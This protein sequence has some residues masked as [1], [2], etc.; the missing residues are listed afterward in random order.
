[1][2]IQYS[3]SLP[4]LSRLVIVLFARYTISNPASKIY[5]DYSKIYLN[6]CLKIKYFDFKNIVL[7]FENYIVLLLQKY[8]FNNA[9]EGSVD[10]FIIQME[11][12]HDIPPLRNPNMEETLTRIGQEKEQNESLL[13]IVRAGKELYQ[14]TFNVIHGITSSSFALHARQQDLQDQGRS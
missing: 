12:L 4:Q 11:L 6:F 7:N 13:A 10:Y 2:N 5:Q 14:E 3:P 8:D 9:R 1:M